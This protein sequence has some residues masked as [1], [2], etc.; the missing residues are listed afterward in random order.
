MLRVCFAHPPRTS[1]KRAVTTT[2]LRLL[3]F[4]FSLT[5]FLLS[6]RWVIHLLWWWSRNRA[7]E[8]VANVVYG[9]QLKVRAPHQRGKGDRR[10]RSP[11]V[12]ARFRGL[13]SLR[14]RVLFRYRTRTRTASLI[15]LSFQHSCPNCQ[16]SYCGKC[17][18]SAVLVPKLGKER[19]VCKT[20]FEALSR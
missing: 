5:L 3:N 15:D 2:P 17:L 4:Y 13:V 18:K 11:D 9:L 7:L 19:K 12:L 6:W 14:D 16:F 20:C 10:R 8:S 1:A